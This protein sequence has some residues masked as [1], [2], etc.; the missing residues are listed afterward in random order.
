[1]NRSFLLSAFLVLALGGCSTAGTGDIGT[2]IDPAGSQTPP[3][4]TSFRVVFDQSNPGIPLTVYIADG[5]DKKEI[6]LDILYPDGTKWSYRAVDVE[7]NKQTAAIVATQQAVA[8]VQAQT[9]QV[10]GQAAIDAI[11]LAVNASLGLPTR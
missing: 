1:M 4:M 6:A 11:A 3:G 9:G 10:L 8:E 2:T 7:G 5:Q